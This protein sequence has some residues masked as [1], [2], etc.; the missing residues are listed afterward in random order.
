MLQ[1]FGQAPE[2]DNGVN[3]AMDKALSLFHK[4]KHAIIDTGTHQGKGGGV[5]K[6]WH[7]PKLELMQVL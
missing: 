3:R 1:D 5:I 6:N 7:I 2:S 4:Y